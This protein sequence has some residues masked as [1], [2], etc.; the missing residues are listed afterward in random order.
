MNN[1]IKND[2]I[3]AAENILEQVKKIE[4]ENLDDVFH[5]HLKIGHTLHH[6]KEFNGK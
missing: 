4:F 6:L 5:L 3:K 2:M 1:T